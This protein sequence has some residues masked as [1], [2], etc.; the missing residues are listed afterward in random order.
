[1]SKIGDRLFNYDFITL[2]LLKKYDIDVIS[3]SNFEIESN[4]IKTLNWIPDFQYLHYSNLWTESQLNSTTQLHDKLIKKSDGI[5]L[6]S[7]AA[8]EDFKINHNS[9]NQKVS[10]LNF[11]SQPDSENLFDLE[12]NEIKQVEY[13]YN[14]DK[15][16]FYVPNQF[17][18]HKNH[19]IVFEA[20]KILKDKGISTLVVTSGLMKDYRKGNNHVDKLLHFVNE[21]DLKENILFLGLIPYSDVIKLIL[22]SKCVINPSFFEGW[23]SSVEESKTAGKKIILSNI[24]VHIEQNPEFGIYF[25]PNNV[26]ELADKM[27]EIMASPDSYINNNDLKICLEKRTSIFAQQYINIIEKLTKSQK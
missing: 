23:S 7:N 5:V 12:K 6:S 9:Y 3:H 26:F 25:D 16:F 21:N 17:W 14:I 4:K 24:P 18:S 2:N 20:V 19:L 13:N 22:M 15:P 11:V 8:F 1:M 27:E 10:V